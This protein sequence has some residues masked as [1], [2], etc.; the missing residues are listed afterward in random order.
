M[1]GFVMANGKRL[2]K[3]Q[4]K[5]YSAVYCGICR[6][7][8]LGYGQMSRLLL[9]YDM[10]FL[11]LLLTSL[12]EPEEVSGKNACGLHPITKRPWVENPYITYAADMNVLLAYYHCKDDYE[13]EGSL[14]SKGAMGLLQNHVQALK[15][16]YP[17]QA[18]A[19]E[20]RLQELSGL[21]KQKCENP[22]LPAGVFGALL[23]ELFS[24]EEDLWKPYLQEVGT[25]LGRFIY[26]AD[27]VV[28]YPKDKKKGNYNPFWKMGIDARRAEEILILEMSRCT[29]AFE[30]L[31]LVQDKKILDNILYSGVWL[32]YGQKMGGRVS[33][34]ET[35]G[36]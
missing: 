13:D 7:L 35:D 10:A 11:A 36:L 25:A 28:D 8:R 26:L 12:Y 31:P 24:P 5:R 3:D 22:D 27:A 6:Q 30:K 18:R 19:V 2:T 21:E 16:K 4:Q 17:K 14:L 20:T 15:V 9:S 32:Q 1:F 33:R 34:E 29:K 23:G